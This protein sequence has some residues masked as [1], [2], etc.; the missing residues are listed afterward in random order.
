MP[1]FE[2]AVEAALELLDAKIQQL[3][4]KADQNELSEAES[5]YLEDLLQERHELANELEYKP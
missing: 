4:E 1:D 5:Y 3:S 2:Q